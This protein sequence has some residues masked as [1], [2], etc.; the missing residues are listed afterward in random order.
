MKLSR[1]L[2]CLNHDCV[3]SIRTADGWA[4]MNCSA[5]E[6]PFWMTQ[7]QILSTNMSKGKL[8]VVVS[9]E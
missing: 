8:S 5:G 2:K 7:R 1:L 3:L 4:E 9:E 6:V